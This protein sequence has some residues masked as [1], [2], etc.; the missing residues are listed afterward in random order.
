[1]SIIINQNGPGLKYDSY[2]KGLSNAIG[3]FCKQ[4]F[5]SATAV[6]KKQFMGRE[7]KFSQRFLAQCKTNHISDQNLG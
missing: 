4:Y 6:C 1:M 5:R 2:K 3:S 7:E